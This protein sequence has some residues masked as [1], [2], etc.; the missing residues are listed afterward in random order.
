ML[1]KGI[2]G[3][4]ILALLSQLW[5]HPDQ[6]LLSIVQGTEI[7]IKQVSRALNR[8]HCLLLSMSNLRNFSPPH[9]ARMMAKRSYNISPVKSLRRRQHTREGTIQER[10]PLTKLGL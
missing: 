10:D 1:R 5:Q 8:G 3:L 6:F 2:P 9:F 4:L 7:V